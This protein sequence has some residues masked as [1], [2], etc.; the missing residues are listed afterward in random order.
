MI[1][2]Q[3]SLFSWGNT[4]IAWIAE[5]VRIAWLTPIM[6]F[7]T[8]LGH[9]GAILFT[10]ALSYWLWNKRYARALL[11][12]LFANI[13]LNLLVKN[14][15]RECRPPHQYWLENV[16]DSYSFPSGHAQI[17][18]YLW[19]G[20][21]FYCKEKWQSVICVLIGLL[22]ALSRP[23]LGVHYPQDITAGA[24]LGLIVLA[25]TLFCEKK[26]IVFLASCPKLVRGII[27]ILIM[28]ILQFIISDPRNAEVSVI[29]STLGFWLGCQLEYRTLDFKPARSLGLF[30]M[31]F[32]IG[33]AGILFFWKGGDWLR[34]L[35]NESTALYVKYL[36][37]FLLGLW[38]GYGAPALV[39]KQ[40]TTQPD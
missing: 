19:F 24:I 20:F 27:L 1:D 12:G 26:N 32:I 2:C 28:G 25:F 38:I 8:E 37:Y 10:T 16:S 7:F 11:Y 9:V 23:Y 31:Q 4:S 14:S 40:R 35:L 39:L 33:A 15:V 30:I 18:V 13:F 36:Q 6:F 34:H 17:G 22:I 21:A 3:P 5:N 29:G